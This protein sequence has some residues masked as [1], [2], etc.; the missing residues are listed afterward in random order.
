MGCTTTCSTGPNARGI[1]GALRTPSHPTAC[2]N[3][4]HIQQPKQG[5]GGT[6]IRLVVGTKRATLVVLATLE[7]HTHSVRT[8]LLDHAVQGN[9]RPDQRLPRCST[10]KSSC[11]GK[12]AVR[13]ASQGPTL[14][15]GGDGLYDHIQSRPKRRKK[16]T[17]QQ[18]TL[19]LL[20]PHAS[21]AR[22]GQR[23]QWGFAHTL[24]SNRMREL[25]AHPATKAG[26]RWYTH[27][28]R[29]RHQESHSGGACHFGQR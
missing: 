11:V 2:V 22:K 10:S 7:L 12:W 19:H 24:P 9:T 28:T 8:A 1:N 21:T 29:G 17:Q 25:G 23:H 4:E 3:W 27:Q 5:S 15:G 20:T 13:S 26:E 16:G 18:L 6:R 14:W